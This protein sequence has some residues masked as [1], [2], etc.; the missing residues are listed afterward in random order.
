MFS[1]VSRHIRK[2]ETCEVY[3]DSKKPDVVSKMTCEIN[4]ANAWRQKSTIDEPSGSYGRW[5]A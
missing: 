1:L 2:W 5:L 3:C 4:V